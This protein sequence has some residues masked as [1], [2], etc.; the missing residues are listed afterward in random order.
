MPIE[1]VVVPLLHLNDTLADAADYL[2]IESFRS[3]TAVPSL[4]RSSDTL[5]SFGALLAYTLLLAAVAFWVFRRRDIAG[6][7][8]E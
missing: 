5:Q 1:P 7:T 2:L 8:G 4:E 6:A 3:W